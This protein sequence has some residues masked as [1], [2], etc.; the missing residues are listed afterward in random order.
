[1]NYTVYVSLQVS[2]VVEVEAESVNEAIEAAIDQADYP[3]SSNSFES[4]GEHW[5][6]I[7][8]Q[9]GVVVHEQDTP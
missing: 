8:Y 2:Q 5:A 1:M 9:D 6:R 4:D 7:V 3:N